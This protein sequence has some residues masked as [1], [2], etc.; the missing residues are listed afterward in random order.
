MS[1]KLRDE[2]HDLSEEDM[3]R[4]RDM[5]EGYSGADMTNLCKEAALGPIRSFSGDIATV[6]KEEVRPI[7]LDDFVGAFKQVRASVSDKDL[8][9][10]LDWNAQFGTSQ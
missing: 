3:G 8:Q 9:G 4:I 7:S 1:N 5:S 2:A 6:R 10:Y